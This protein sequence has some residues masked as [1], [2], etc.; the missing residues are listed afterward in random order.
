MMEIKVSIPGIE[1]LLDYSASGIGS[2]AGP[3]L[4]SWGDSVAT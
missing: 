1:K 3:M 4:V 2:V